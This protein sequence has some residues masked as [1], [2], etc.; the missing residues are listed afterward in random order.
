MAIPFLRIKGPMSSL[1]S[2]ESMKLPARY[3]TGR[4][5]ASFSTV[6]PARVP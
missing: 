6:R 3:D 4:E 5:A 2:G 1:E